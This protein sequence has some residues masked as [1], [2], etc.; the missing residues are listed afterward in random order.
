[1]EQFEKDDEEHT[2]QVIASHNHRAL[3]R[4]VEVAA[5]RQQAIR[6]RGHSAPASSSASSRA[7]GVDG[8]S[9]SGAGDAADSAHHV[10]D[11]RK[12][13]QMPR[14][15]GRRN[16]QPLDVSLERATHCR[17]QAGPRLRFFIR[18]PRTTS[19]KQL[20]PYIRRRMHLHASADVRFAVLLDSQTNEVEPL[21]LANQI[22]ALAHFFAK[23]TNGTLALVYFIDDDDAADEKI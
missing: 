8:G 1:M 4:R 12:V 5:A 6:G 14:R 16:I 7:K 2:R 23:K 22:D 18:I 3:A 9:S 17:T 13:Y 10:S 20:V 19:L 15:V 11:D 21:E